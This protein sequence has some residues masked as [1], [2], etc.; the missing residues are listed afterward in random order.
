MLAAGWLLA[1]T[2][3]GETPPTTDSPTTAAFAA[4][5][6]RIYQE[7]LT[8]WRAEGTN[9]EAAWQFARASFDWADYSTNDAQ[10]ADIAERAIEGCRRALQLEPKLAAAHY[11]LAL[12]LGQLART[13]LLGALKLVQEMEEH[14]KKTIELDPRLDYAGGHRSLGV[15]YRD[16][17]GWPTSIGSRAK[18][19]QHLESAVGLAPE[20][21][22][23][24]LEWL[25]S[26]LKWGDKK[27]AQTQVAS[28]E[29]LL[30]GARAKFTGERWQADW[31][32]WDQ[33][34]GQLKTKAAAHPP[35]DK[36]P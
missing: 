6:Q 7:S 18:A 20:Y 8:R 11:Y 10:R 31:R 22:G 3:F 23:N 21:P 16:A 34:W 35:P 26:L 5:F 27:K 24:Q 36:V 30:P 2:S 32:E 25:D 15:L 1:S 13:K 29:K 19:R 12:N 28:I 14:F 9:A 33:R 4:R 17:P